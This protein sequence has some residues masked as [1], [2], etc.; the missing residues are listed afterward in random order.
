MSE[1]ITRNYQTVWSQLTLILSVKG[2]MDVTGL[3][4]P[5]KRNAHLCGVR[6]SWLFVSFFP[7]FLDWF[8]CVLLIM[9][10]MPCD[11]TIAFTGQYRDTDSNT[12][13]SISHFKCLS[14]EYP[15]LP[16]MTCIVEAWWCLLPTDHFESLWLMYCCDIAVFQNAWTGRNEVRDLVMTVRWLG[17]DFEMTSRPWLNR[18][19]DWGHGGQVTWSWPRSDRVMT[20]VG[21]FLFKHFGKQQ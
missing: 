6:V 4:A 20:K 11:V 21:D 15:L 2:I 1:Q 14:S 17:H 12:T 9:S 18:V 7:F 10:V 19:I 13:P 3:L 16:C 5:E 8:D